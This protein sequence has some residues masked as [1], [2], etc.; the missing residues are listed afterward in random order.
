MEELEYSC[1]GVNLNSITSLKSHI[2]S[3]GL[4]S[5]NWFADNVLPNCDKLQVLDFSDTI[6]MQ[7]R[8][9][10]CMGIKSLLLALSDKQIRK[11]NLSD[12]FLDTDGA[13]AFAAFL[14]VNQTLEHLQINNCALG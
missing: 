3:W 4:S 9:D 5:N 10:L 1:K 12:N 13:R 2:N 7:H 6:N 8:S 14:E 11:V